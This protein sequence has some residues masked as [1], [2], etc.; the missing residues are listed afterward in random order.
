MPDYPA[1]HR[2]P[3][4]VS[5]GAGRVMKNTANAPQPHW[6]YSEAFYHTEE[7]AQARMD[8]M[9]AALNAALKPAVVDP[10]AKDAPKLSDP[11]LPNDNQAGDGSRWDDI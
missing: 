4:P 7:A 2:N 5:N 11:L 10:K 3:A 6:Q 9:A 1:Y 8:D